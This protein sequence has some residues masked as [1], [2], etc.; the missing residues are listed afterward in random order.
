MRNTLRITRFVLIGLLVCWGISLEFNF[1][2]ATAQNAKGRVV[3]VKGDRDPFSPWKPVA[4][5]KKEVAGQL[6]VA[7]LE[8][9]ISNYKSLKAAAM[10]SQQ[11]AP[12]PTTAFL[13]NEVQI[14]GIFHTPRGYAAMVEVTPIKLSYIIYPGEQFFDG[15]LVAIEEDRLVFRHEIRLTN[16]KKDMTVVNKPLRSPSV[17]ND[18]LTA[19]KATSPAATPVEAPREQPKEQS[20]QIPASTPQNN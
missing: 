16:G 11:P 1:N 6:P 17:I 5:V 3:K 20:A 9:R 19:S 7:S 15:Q 4:S 10:S 8:N 13:L 18:A 14:V 2:T 12:K